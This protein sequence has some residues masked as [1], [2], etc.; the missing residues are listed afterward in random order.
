MKYFN[1]KKA[2]KDIANLSQEILSTSIA[3]FIKLIIK[4]R[5]SKLNATGTIQSFTTF[6]MDQIL[7]F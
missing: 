3:F 1:N 6:P 2:T 4:K 5:I 7:I